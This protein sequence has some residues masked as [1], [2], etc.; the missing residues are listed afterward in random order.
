VPGKTY[1][2]T[3]LGQYLTTYD[4][5]VACQI[6][7]EFIVENGQGEWME[8]D[9]QAGTAEFGTVVIHSWGDTEITATA[10]PNANDPAQT[11]CV[12]T[13]DADG[14]PAPTAPMTPS[15]CS[16]T[17]G[18]PV[19]IGCP[20]PTIASVSP[21][22]WFAGK[23]YKATITGTNFTTNNKATDACP[24]TTVTI[25]AADGS[26]VP[27]GS[28]SV[29]SDTKITLAGVAP[30]DSDPTQSATITAGASPNTGTFNTAQILGNQIKC[31]ASMPNCGGSVISTTDGSDPPA[32]NVVV[33][34]Q[35]A[36][37]T[38]ALPSGITATSMTWTV[39][40]TRIAGN[41]P[42]TSKTT[43]K[44]LT[45]LDLKKSS[46]TLYWVYPEDDNIPVTYK[47]C[48]DIPGADPVRQC[49]PDA[50]AS[51]RV[52]GVGSPY[53]SLRL[54]NGSPPVTIDP[55]E[56]CNGSG[57]GDYLVYGRLWGQINPCTT[58]GQPGI[59][60]F[61]H[62]TPPGDGNLFFVQIVNSDHIAERSGD[63]VSETCDDTAGLD[64]DYPYLG[65]LN[66]RSVPDAPIW[67]LDRE[68]TATTRNFD[69]WMYL[70]WQSTST[71]NSIP[72]PLAYLPWNFEGTAVPAGSGWTANGR[73]GPTTADGKSIPAASTQPNEGYPTWNGLTETV[74]TKR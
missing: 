35:I 68:Y 25:A 29:D 73:G 27:I 61:P 43:V 21:N 41:N 16:A 60:F 11:A 17:G 38:P 30:P 44:E 52:G 36:L 32:Q 46:I 14:D 20:A 13:I 31:A 10:K 47:Y 59:Q 40:G 7:K 8:S 26:A 18:F 51:F 70:F 66:P 34:Q 49:S 48:V 2:I 65:Q 6:G 67:Q 24:A 71:A 9:G 69:A 5:A 45:D 37:T 62:G 23:S 54:F 19:Q 1:N 39:G 55:L 42:T 15:L 28:V 74:C 56:A 72:V 58:Y 64:G 22:T 50:T 3:V 12:Y 53:I 33:G 63:V 57:A 4:P